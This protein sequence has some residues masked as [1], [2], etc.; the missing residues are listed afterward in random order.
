MGTILLLLVLV[1]AWVALGAWWLSGRQTERPVDSIGSFR[2][3]LGTLERRSPSLVPPAN[4]MRPARPRPMVATG[5]SHRPGS[6]FAIAAAR[7]DISYA[8]S[9]RVVARH[10][11][12]DVFFGLVLTASLTFLG[13]FVPTLRLLWVACAVDLILLAT[14]CSL[15]VRMRNL[16]AE[17]EMKI[18]YLSTA[19]ERQERLHP[20]RPRPAPAALRRS[21]N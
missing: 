12:R 20:G 7:G 10:R 18:R 13:G 6:G 4:R 8:S 9:Q 16:A 15:L 2:R 14:F 21:A 1:G 17:R 3:Q 19:R 11:R 5:Q